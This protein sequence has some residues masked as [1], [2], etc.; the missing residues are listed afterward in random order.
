[1]TNLLWSQA[2][3]ISACRLSL[4]T[5]SHATWCKL[6]SSNS[7]KAE[8]VCL[9]QGGESTIWG[10]WVGWIQ[11]IL[12]GQGCT[13]CAADPTSGKIFIFLSNSMSYYLIISYLFIS[14]C[15]FG[16][17]LNRSRPHK[18]G[19]ARYQNIHYCIQVLTVECWALLIASLFVAGIWSTSL[20]TC[21][22]LLLSR[23]LRTSDLKCIISSHWINI[24]TRL[25]AIIYGICKTAS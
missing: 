6:A 20:G 4:T 23:Y 14:G 17:K 25:L 7:S 9:L 18:L 15:D 5:T 1:M 13:L 10:A 12:C 22:G 11:P 16:C 21:F 8:S 24:P 2:T 19:S 3:W